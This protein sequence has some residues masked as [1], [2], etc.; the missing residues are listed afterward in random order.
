MAHTR[1]GTIQHGAFFQLCRIA[2]MSKYTN[3]VTVGRSLSNT[4]ARQILEESERA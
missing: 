1:I 3:Q 2:G 4:K